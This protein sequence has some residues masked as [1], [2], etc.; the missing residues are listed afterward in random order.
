MGMSAPSISAAIITFNEEENI[1]RCLTS[2]AWVDEIMVVDSGSTD[3]TL[4]I[5][6]EYDCLV[7]NHVW[8]GYARQK[9]LAI[10][11]AT[12]DW[13]LS[14][15]GDEEVT[16]ELA[17]EIRAVIASDNP[18]E[19][20]EIPR[21]NMFLGKWMRHGGWYPDRQRRLLKR[22]RGAFK[23]VA[24]H[25]HIELF[26]RSARIGCLSH[27]MRHYTYPT[28]RDFVLRADSYTSIEVAAISSPGRF[29]KRP[30]LALVTAFPLKFLETYVYKGGWRDGIH[31]FIAA[32]LTATRVFI[33]HV[34]IWEASASK[35]DDR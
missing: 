8:E 14:I 27:P 3:N 31:G 2:L 5:C 13:V 26:D 1:R 34:K 30:G 23:E 15:D 16:P 28:A 21:S 10:S 12:S 35:V 4:Q 6:K 9:N 25:E 7:F 32:V 20:Y 22:G 17:E 33:R 11:K 24:L 19:A 29:P 18:A